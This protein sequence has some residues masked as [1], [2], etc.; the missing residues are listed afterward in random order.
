MTLMLA[1]WLV[2][3][4]DGFRADAIPYLWK[5]AGTNCENLPKTHTIV[6]I[7]R[8]AMDYLRPGSILLAEANQPPLEVAKYFADGDECL[9]AYHFPAHAAHL[10]RPR[11]R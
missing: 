10:P 9:A 7:F 3:G 6:K 1:R 11:R 2:R 4:V 8:A 5:E